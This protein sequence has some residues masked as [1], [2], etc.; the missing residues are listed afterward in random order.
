M[1]GTKVRDGSSQKLMFGGAPSL[2]QSLEEKMGSPIHG[3][4]GSPFYSK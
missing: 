1:V 2:R 4:M 3:D